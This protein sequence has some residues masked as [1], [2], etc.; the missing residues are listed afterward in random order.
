M[1]SSGW[2]IDTS[3]KTFTTFILAG[4]LINV[5]PEIIDQIY[6]HKTTGGF[7]STTIIYAVFLGLLFFLKNIFNLLVTNKLANAI[8]W[9]IILGLFG[10][11][12]EWNL[13]GNSGV[14]WY[15][16]IVMFTFWGSFA[17]VPSIFAEEPSFW[18]LKR[19]IVR[20][21]VPWIFLYLLAGIPSPNLGT[22]IWLLGCAGLNYFY[23]KYFRL[24]GASK[25]PRRDFSTRSEDQVTA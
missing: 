3:M 9:Y 10:L 13:I 18:K 5:P 11:F 4:L 19:A 22:L 1:K 15:G 17:M 7:I 24:L 6:V 12:V 25:S 20:Y 21:S 23:I 16:Q 14:A 2:C 8:S